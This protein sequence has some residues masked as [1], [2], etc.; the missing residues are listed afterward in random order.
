MSGV[1]LLR[2]PVKRDHDRSNVSR[3]AALEPLNCTSAPLDNVTGVISSYPALLRRCSCP[4]KNSDLKV[5]PFTGSGMATVSL[6][7]ITVTLMW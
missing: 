4:F 1:F 3:S 5:P 6:T 2:M 7:I